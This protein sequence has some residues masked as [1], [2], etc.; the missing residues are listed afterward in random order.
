LSGLTAIL[1]TTGALATTSGTALAALA[2]RRTEKRQM[3]R[4]LQIV[5]VDSLPVMILIA[6]LSGF[7]MVLESSSYV[8]SL[9]A[10][11]MVGWAFGLVTL[12]QV[13]PVLVALMFAARAG[14][15]TTA[16][17][18]AMAVTGQLDALR[19]LAVDPVEYLAAPRFL[20]MIVMLPLMTA[21]CD[22]I[23]VAAGAVGATLLVGLTPGL[24]WQSLVDG[25]L[26]D[27]FLM[28]I[29]KCFFFGGAIAAV[30]CTFGLRV[31]GGAAGAGRAVN[32]CV[33][34]SALAIFVIDF[35]FTIVVL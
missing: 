17:L 18:G 8:E 33:V 28:G 13:A 23:A 24:F 16:E 21:L 2:R 34:V 5:S 7:V 15:R 20:A 35:L 25:N 9:G 19:L 29:G 30:S 12:S 32:D 14:A 4:Q 26:L 27:E 3:L 22:I 1:E 11:S 10:Y 31:T 6:T